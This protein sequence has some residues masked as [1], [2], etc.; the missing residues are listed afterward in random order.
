MPYDI[1]LSDFFQKLI[2]Q[3]KKK[4]PHAGDDLKTGLGLL[5]RQ[6]DLGKSIEGVEKVRKIR[7]RN[8]DIQK[9]KSGG[10]RLIYLEDGQNILIIPLIMYSKLQ[11]EDVT[12]N[13]LR[14]LI[15]RML[16][17]YPPLS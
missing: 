5:V 10:Y 8:S 15:A 9:G 14:I 12:V 1:Y 7:L 11:R 6:P 17:E 2:K 13:E 16:Q 4:Y 3:L